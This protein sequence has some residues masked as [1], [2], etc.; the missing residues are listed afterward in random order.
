MIPKQVI[1]VQTSFAHVRSIADVAAALFYKRLF[2][3]DPSLRV[4]FH[5]DMEEQGRK[6]MAM[7]SLVIRGLDRLEL[8][9]PAIQQ[10]GGRHHGYG[11]RAEHYATVGAALIW[12]L[13]QGLG[14]RF[15]PD[16]AAA[17]ASAYQLLS[18]TMQASAPIGRA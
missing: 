12:T 9:V 5:G 8:L 1:L 7:L 3:L 4:L 16:V 2:E 10:L 13:G 6:L 11:I 18:D 15:T 17:W 14:E